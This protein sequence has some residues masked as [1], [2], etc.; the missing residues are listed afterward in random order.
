MPVL[1]LTMDKSPGLTLIF[2]FDEMLKKG[3]RALDLS[4]G[5]DALRVQVMAEGE[6]TL[7]L[8]C[9]G[10]LTGAQGH[11]VALL[12]WSERLRDRL[13]LLAALHY[14]TIICLSMGEWQAARNYGERGSAESPKDH[15]FLEQLAVLEHELG[16]IDPGN[17]CLE[18]FSDAVGAISSGANVQYTFNANV[19]PYVARITGD[20]SL[21]PIAERAA[22]AVLSD[23]A[24]AP[25]QARL[26]SIGLG[27]MVVDRQDPVATADVYEFLEQDQPG[28]GISGIMCFHRLLG[29]LSH[30]MGNL[31][32]AAGHFE[33]GLTFCRAGYRVELA[34]T[35][36][37]YADTLLQRNGEGAGPRPCPC[38]TSS[39]PSPANLVCGL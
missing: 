13:Y 17:R 28:M 29:L 34:W 5:S 19:I 25:M 12:N 36:C 32:Q 35:C 6:I 9:T 31:D 37:D 10:D 33:D 21:M 20:V 22:G 11:A 27:L 18:E 24:I 14:N 26:V 3:Q 30:T 8:Y 16:N 2:L 1:A 7:A 38:W 39:W 15:R 23:S 4:A